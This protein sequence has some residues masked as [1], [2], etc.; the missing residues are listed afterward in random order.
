MTV[1]DAVAIDLLNGLQNI[2]IFLIIQLELIQYVSV[3]DCKQ[4]P[5]LAIMLS[6]HCQLVIQPELLT[7]AYAKENHVYMAVLQAFCT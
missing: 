1:H 5:S 6:F 4:D 7:G 2:I 3:D